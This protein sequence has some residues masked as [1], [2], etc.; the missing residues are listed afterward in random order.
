MRFRR[1]SEDVYLALVS[2]L[3]STVIPTS[4][5][6]ITLVIMDLFAWATTGDYIFLGAGIA[7][8]LASIGKL[9]L[10]LVQRLLSKRGEMDIQEAERWEFL[11]TLATTIVAASVGAVVYAAFIWHSPNVQV[12]GTALLFGYCSGVVARLSLRPKIAIVALV[13]SVGPAIV[14]ASQANT[15]AHHMIAVMYGVFLLGAFD[16]V[17]HVYTSAMRHIVSRLEMATLARHDPLTGLANRLGLRE[18]FRSASQLPEHIAVHC[19]DLDGFK[20]V[21]DQFGHAGGDAI[22]VGVAQRLQALDPKNAIVARFGGDEFVVLQMG[23]SQVS[24]AER[25]A[26]R[27]VDTLTQPFPLENHVVEIGASLGFAVDSASSNLN[28]LLLRADEASYLI[29][30]N[31]GGAALASG[32]HFFSPSQERFRST[33]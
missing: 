25:L 6:G 29:K 4:I 5:M 13:I 10:M 26:C 14:G 16:T 24:D 33:S 7:G 27:I 22:L 32:K 11:H 30:R 12:M 21:N 17:R 28:D 15:T 1:E 8:G 20:G 9:C 19:L 23:V 3:S 31:G 18:A 2:D